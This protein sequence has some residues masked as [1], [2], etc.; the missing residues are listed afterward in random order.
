[1]KPQMVGTATEMSDRD[2]ALKLFEYCK[3]LTE[4]QRSS[5]LGFLF[6]YLSD[7]PRFVAGVRHYLETFH[8]EVF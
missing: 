7:E 1:M 4:T 3:A 2:D 6:G 8:P 5:L